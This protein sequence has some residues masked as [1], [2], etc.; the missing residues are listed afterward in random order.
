MAEFRIVDV[1]HAP[2]ALRQIVRDHLDAHNIAATGLTDYASVTLLL[3]DSR[4][5]VRGGLLGAMWG[6]CLHIQILWVAESL[7]GRGH[8]RRLLEAAET[9][10]AE[11]GCLN[12]FLETFSFQAPLFYQKL[13]YEVFGEADDWPEGHTHYFLRKRLESK[14]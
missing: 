13:G 6:R 9:L 11:R 12:A 4:E 5:E 3:K 10:A 7:R 14:S 8:G 1:P 2:A